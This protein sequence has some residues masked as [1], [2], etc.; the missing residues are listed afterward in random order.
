MAK[1]KDTPGPQQQPRSLAPDL[2]IQPEK[3][4]AGMYAELRKFGQPREVRQ[5]LLSEGYQEDSKELE[6]QQIEV[7][8]LD[9]TIPEDRALSALQ[10]LLDRT[11]YG[12]NVPGQKVN[13]EGYKWRGTLP[14][15]VMT[16]SEYLE[17]YGLEMREGQY[18]KGRQAQEAI[19]ALERLTE[20]RRIV[21]R[22]R[23]WKGK[24]QVSDVIVTKGPLILIH[25]GY[26]DLEEEEADRVE[27]GE[28]LPQRVSRL[29][30]DFSP[31]LVDSVDRFY[32]IKPATLHQEIYALLGAKRV[33][34]SISL[35]IQWL[36]T[37]NTTTVKIA[38]DK[39]AD[40]LRLDG[41]IRQRKRAKVEERIQEAIQVAL[42]LEYLLDCQEDP[43]GV[44]TFELNPD[45]M[46]RPTRGQAEEPEEGEEEI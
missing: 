25:K 26:K 19:K 34:R 9:L 14:R 44:L 39:L 37:K 41:L 35:F 38:K 40:R 36:L 24:K 1:A 33:S 3:Y 15:L 23:H 4:R 2:I 30:I 22:R 5:L 16:Y 28:E 42:E 12:G 13:S 29:V 6:E 31:L 10:I 46:G 27:A 45:K 21:Y 20:Q 11:G 8:G 17:A 7:S 18:Y 43:F 32:L